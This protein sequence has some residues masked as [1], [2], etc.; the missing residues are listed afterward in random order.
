M[1]AVSPL[2]PE[3]EGSA[4]RYCDS[5][6]RVFTVHRNVPQE[7]IDDLARASGWHIGAEEIF[8]PGCRQARFSISDA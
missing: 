6:G 4:D 2:S 5:C 8:C 1:T 3:T 7:G